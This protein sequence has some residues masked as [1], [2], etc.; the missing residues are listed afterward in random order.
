MSCSAGAVDTHPSMR[1]HGGVPKKPA[2]RRQPGLRRR[3]PLEL[4]AEELGLLEPAWERFGT[5]RAAL[6]AGLKTLNGVSSRAQDGGHDWKSTQQGTTG[7]NVAK[8]HE[9]SDPTLLDDEAEPSGASYPNMGTTTRVWADEE[10]VVRGLVETFDAKEI[11]KEKLPAVR[12]SAL[13]ADPSGS[14]TSGMDA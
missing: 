2:S 3:I 11:G 9:R 5:M 4:T 8:A 12:S 10:S 1:L 14:G 6:V 13:N 7:E